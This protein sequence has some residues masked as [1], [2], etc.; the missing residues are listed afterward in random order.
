MALSTKPAPLVSPKFP[1]D[2]AEIGGSNDD[3]SADFVAAPTSSW[4]R[5]LKE[6]IRDPEELCRLLDL[7]SSLV[8][9]ARRA[10]EQFGLFVP[11]GYVNRMRRGDPADPLLRQ[12]LP[13]GEE[14]VD[15]AG[16]TTD[17][18]GDRPAELVPGLLQKYE[19][20]ALLIA[21]GAC[22][23]HCRYCFRRHYPYDTAPKS[24]AQWERALAAIAAD[25]AIDEVILSGGDPWTLVDDLLAPLAARIADIPHVRRLRVHTR[26]PIF[27]P[28]RVCD[29]L[30]EWFSKAALSK[31]GSQLTPICVI[32]ANH[33]AELDDEVAAAL[34]R[35]QQAGVMLLNQTVL[36]RGV[37]D[38][39][40]ALDGLCRRLVDL[41]VVPY[42][43][44][45]LDRVAGAAH[46]EVP[47]ADGLRLVE[48]LRARLP[49]YAVPR[50]VRE[51]PGAG[52]K[53][54]LGL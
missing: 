28:E 14:L 26:L 13:L 21:T 45:Q 20:R 9:A 19:S 29:S 48:A 44:H 24:L 27:I 23:V 37:N 4:R 46:F 40:A 3:R 53:T 50:Y 32:H 41:G 33:A 34:A 16:F 31:T 22:A 36:L 7:P 47:E 49:G 2:G 8:P 54:P 17:P 38:S 51:V 43:L 12:V 5:T 10:A 52:S 6:A 30:L 1:P 42:Y 15:V 39:I 25:P 18:V 11:R 35:L